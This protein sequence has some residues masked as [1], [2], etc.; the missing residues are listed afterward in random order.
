MRISKSIGVLA[1]VLAAGLCVAAVEEA[2]TPST[3]ATPVVVELYTSQGCSSCPPADALLGELAKRAD[4]VALS[5]HVDYWDYIGWK[6]PYASPST[7]QRQRAYA[8]AMGQ[9]MIYTPQMVID[10]RTETVGSHTADVERLIDEARAHPKLPIAFHRDATGYYVELPAGRNP[11]PAPATVWLVIYDKQHETAVD[12]GENAGADLVDYNV[13]REWRKIGS[14]DGKPM[15]LALGVSE[16]ME[17][18]HDGCAVI[19][20]AGDV[21]PILGAA[22]FKMR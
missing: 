12:R 19:L 3:T 20:Q 2:V 14:W 8:H 18:E 5:L 7:T 15:K 21:G 6:D 10:G 11:S 4:I 1:A 17:T 13:V 16:D 22:A 9:H